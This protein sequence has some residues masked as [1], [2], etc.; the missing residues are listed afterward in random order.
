MEIIHYN[1]DSGKAFKERVPFRALIQSVQRCSLVYEEPEVVAQYW[2]AP[3]DNPLYS[4]ILTGISSPKYVTSPPESDE[5][6]QAYLW[7]DDTTV[8]VTF[9]GSSNMDDFAADVDV[10]SK[11]LFDDDRDINVHRGFLKQFLSI[12]PQIRDFL[13]NDPKAQALSTILV[14][15]HSLGGGLAHIA[16][17]FYGEMFN[18]DKLLRKSIF[19]HTFGSPRTGNDAFVDWFH[20]NVQENYRVANYQDPIP[21]I[22]IRSVFSHVKHTCILMKKGEENKFLMCIQEHDVPFWIRIWAPIF[23]I[24]ERKLLS[25]K[26]FPEHNTTMFYYP[27]LKAFYEET[28]DDAHRAPSENDS[29]NKSVCTNIETAQ[30]V[31]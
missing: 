7:T 12:E 13:N 3:T 20:K 6:A 25:I 9:R 1:F 24:T 19:C 29:D 18:G 31:E 5:D 16:A 10:I 11:E 26:H 4:D 22:P 14:C 30:S 28:N 27:R 2:L 23:C 15:G 17:P 21:T 8:Y